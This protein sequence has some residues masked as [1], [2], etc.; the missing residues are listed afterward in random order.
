M[1]STANDHASNPILVIGA[2]PAGIVTGYFLQRAG[3]PY[4]II[5]RADVIASTWANLYPSLRLNT[6]RYF[7][8]MPGRRFPLKWGEFPTGKQ[9]HDYVAGFVDAHRLN[10][11]LG[12]DVS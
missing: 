11:T 7:S 3:L 6:T 2:G 1:K 12:V 9:Y 10:I 5:D 8:H 4:E